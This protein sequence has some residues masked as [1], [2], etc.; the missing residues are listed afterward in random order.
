MV[1]SSIVGE[2]RGGLRHGMSQSTP[3]EDRRPRRSTSSQERPL[4]VTSVR[5]VLTYAYRTS[6]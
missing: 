1:S 4:L 3:L 2:D 6:S 5:P